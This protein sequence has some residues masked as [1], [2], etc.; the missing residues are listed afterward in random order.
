MTLANSPSDNL[1]DGSC[2]LCAH[3][4]CAN[5]DARFAYICPNC[6]ASFSL[7]LGVTCDDHHPESVRVDD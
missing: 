5:C 1:A 7:P 4:E 2:R 3:G 6:R